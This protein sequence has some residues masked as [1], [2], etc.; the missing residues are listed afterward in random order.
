MAC[1]NASLPR[2]EPTMV[3]AIAAADRGSRTGTRLCW[4]GMI[5]PR[6]ECSIPVAGPAE[7]RL[8]ASAPARSRAGRP[9]PNPIETA[10]PPPGVAG[11]FRRVA[12]ALPGIQAG[13]AGFV[14]EDGNA[15]LVEECLDGL[16]PTSAVVA[17][18]PGLGFDVAATAR[19]S[20]NGSQPRD[21][22]PRRVAGM[23]AATRTAYA[24][25]DGCSRAARYGRRP[26]RP[27][28]PPHAPPASVR[29]TALCGADL[30]PSPTHASETRR[31]TE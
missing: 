30:A 6:L 12:L 16:W 21:R 3:Q 14:D 11:G 31:G 7:H 5:S 2:R 23:G 4:T 8:S 27:A 10:P 28:R 18:R 19:V 26:V 17:R 1:L 9:S 22:R 15:S 20:E 25:P 29:L 24:L 13:T